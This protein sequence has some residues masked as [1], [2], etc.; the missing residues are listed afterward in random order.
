MT[1]TPSLS[2]PS[3]TNLNELKCYTPYTYVMPYLL[4]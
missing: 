4:K 1:V 3:V 2:Y